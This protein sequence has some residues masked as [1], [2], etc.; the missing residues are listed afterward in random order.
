MLTCS[1]R[2]EY[3]D[4]GRIILYKCTLLSTSF[5]VCLLMSFFFH[6]V[7]HSTKNFFIS[8]TAF[9]MEIQFNFNIDR[10][11]KVGRLGHI[12]CCG[13]LVPQQGASK[14]TLLLIYMWIWRLFVKRCV[15]A[16]GKWRELGRHET[17]SFGKLKQWTLAQLQI[18]SS[19]PCMVKLCLAKRPS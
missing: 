5:W 16:V 3:W 1:S 12:M 4:M 9:P 11:Y 6:S 7:I 19:V 14:Q 13:A 18:D 15:K 8:K 10:M 2:H 17:E